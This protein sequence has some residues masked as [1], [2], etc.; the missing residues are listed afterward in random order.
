MQPRLVSVELIYCG[1]PREIIND[2]GYGPTPATRDWTW[3]GLDIHEM[4]YFRQVRRANQG[5]HGISD[6]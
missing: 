2:L 4:P 1:I 6:R 5:W 3:I